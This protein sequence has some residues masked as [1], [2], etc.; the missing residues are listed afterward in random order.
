MERIKARN[1][2][3]GRAVQRTRTKIQTNKIIDRLTFSPQKHKQKVKRNLRQKLHLQPQLLQLPPAMQTVTRLKFGA[4]NVNGLDLEASW[5]IEQLLKDREFDV[6]HQKYS[7]L[8]H[9]FFRNR[10]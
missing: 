8:S 4:F 6:R 2:N 9:F 5:T 1:K 7:S 3:I 10:S